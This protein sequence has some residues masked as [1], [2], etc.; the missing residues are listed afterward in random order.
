MVALLK[1]ATP[2]D[3]TPYRVIDR[4]VLTR[5]IGVVA[6]S[7]PTDAPQGASASGAWGDAIY[8]VKTGPRS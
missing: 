7:K 4:E 5:G 8:A 3:G 6:A 1:D 2:I